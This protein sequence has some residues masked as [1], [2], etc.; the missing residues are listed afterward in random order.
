MTVEGKN[1]S[2]RVKSVES[3]VK[4]SLSPDMPAAYRLASVAFSSR[5]DN[6]RSRQQVWPSAHLAPA[7][8]TKLS[9]EAGF[10]LDG[11]QWRGCGQI[12]GFPRQT[13]LLAS[14]TASRSTMLLRFYSSTVPT[15][16]RSRNQKDT[17]IYRYAIVLHRSKGPSLLAPEQ[18]EIRNML[19]EN[20]Q[21][22][23][24]SALACQQVISDR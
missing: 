22:I 5:C 12:S 15:W 14:P 16:P 13:P 2:I 3:R 1:R 20:T 9:L 19:F 8:S 6:L 23:L 21:C 10:K 17:G 7:V 18:V 4:S 24:S 11:G